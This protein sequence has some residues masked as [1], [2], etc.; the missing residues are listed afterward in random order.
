MILKHHQL[1]VTA[2]RVAVLQALAEVGRPI[3][4]QEMVDYLAD[5][6]YDPATLYRNLVRLGEEGIAPVVSHAGG[7]DRYALAG[8]GDG[9]RHPHFVC[10]DCGIVKCI[11]LDNN[12]NDSTL[13]KRWAD[14]IGRATIQLQGDCPDCL[15][16]KR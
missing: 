16:S 11:E 1:R 6:P 3:S 4:H 7:V 15:R 10:S 13:G 14:A 8:A 9:H 5:T 12:I 2:P